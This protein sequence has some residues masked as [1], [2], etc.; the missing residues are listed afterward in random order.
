[1]RP[2]PSRDCTPYRASGDSP[3]CSC[4]PRPR[5]GCGPRAAHLAAELI[6]LHHLIA[7][8]PRHRT[9]DILPVDLH[10]GLAPGELLVAGVS[11]DLKHDGVV[12][13]FHWTFLSIGC[14]TQRLHIGHSA[15]SESHQESCMPQSSHRSQR[16]RHNLISFCFISRVLPGRENHSAYR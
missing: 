4:P 5:V 10:L 13:A 1:M 3:D 14:T 6:A 9:A 11:R 2:S 12:Q 15:L 16:N 7:Q 8:F